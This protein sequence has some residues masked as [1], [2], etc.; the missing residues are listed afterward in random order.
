MGTIVNGCAFGLNEIPG[1][2]NLAKFNSN[3]NFLGL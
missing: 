3:L 2:K 1:K